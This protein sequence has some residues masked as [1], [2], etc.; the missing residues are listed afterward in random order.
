MGG[1][2]DRGGAE[3]EAQ[4]LFA[5]IHQSPIATVVTDPRQH[6]YP[7]VAANA[8]FTGLTGYPVEEILGRNC[9]FLAGPDSE[10]KARGSLRQAVAQRQPALVHMLNYRKD[11][12]RF[13][14]AVMVAPVLGE[15][16]ETLYFVGS[17]MEVRDDQ[18]ARQTSSSRMVADLPP[19]QR[20]VLQHMVR[21][22][23]NKQIAAFLGIGEKTVK[24]HRAA[25]LKRLEATSTAD[26][27]RVG[28]EAGIV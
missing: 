25:L 17:Q 7:I 19:R 6:D 18:A 3:R 20:Q 13:R 12:S 8:A 4:R 15:D 11:G 27:I 24:M 5:S 10:D 28:I 9:R 26:A 2:R 1:S 23:R 14:N 16:G 22:L 21:G